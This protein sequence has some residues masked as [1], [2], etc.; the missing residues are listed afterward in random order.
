MSLKNRVSVTRT[1]T[2]T[3]FIRNMKRM[4]QDRW[5]N[6]HDKAHPGTVKAYPV[7]NYFISPTSH[8]L[9]NN[10]LRDLISNFK[11]RLVAS[12][13]VNPRISELMLCRSWKDG[14]DFRE[15]KNS[16]GIIKIKKKGKVGWCQ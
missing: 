9:H 16:N 8:C 11:F 12:S 2:Q 13:P 10:L 6:T 14:S 5:P 1:H 7:K 15:N 3:S 4:Q